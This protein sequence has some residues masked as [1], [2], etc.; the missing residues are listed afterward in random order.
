MIYD[1]MMINVIVENKNEHEIKRN[2]FIILNVFN[3]SLDYFLDDVLNIAFCFR[4]ITI[5]PKV[6]SLYIF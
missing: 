4:I 5:T 6:Y 3:Y 1:I 2:L